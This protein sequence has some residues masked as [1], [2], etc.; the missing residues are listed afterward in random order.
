MPKTES[1][2]NEAFERFRRAE[3]A[4]GVGFLRFKFENE[5]EQT[6]GGWACSLVLVDFNFGDVRLSAFGLGTSHGCQ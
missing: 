5:S 1:K 6:A 3:Q 2:T 4:N